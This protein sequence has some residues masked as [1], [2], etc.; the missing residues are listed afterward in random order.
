[1]MVGVPLP[2]GFQQRIDRWLDRAAF[3][4][5]G[6]C[7]APGLSTPTGPSDTKKAFGNAPRYFSSVRNPGVH[8]LDFSVQ[9]DFAVPVREQMRF[10]FRADF[11]NLPNHPQ[12]AEPVGDLL[13][14]NFGKITRTSAGN[15]SVQLGFHFYF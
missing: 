10:Q 13:S 2:A 7:P 15:R 8:N 9:K 1:M 11:F 3:D 4:F 12:F 5:S 6:T 14:S